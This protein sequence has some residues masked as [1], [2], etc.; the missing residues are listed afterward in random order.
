MTRIAEPLATGPF[1]GFF[2]EGATLYRLEPP[3]IAGGPTE[4]GIKTCE[5]SHII[6]SALPADSEG[7]GPE[8][9]VYAADK[10]GVVDSK[11]YLTFGVILDLNGTA[12]PSAA[13]ARLGYAA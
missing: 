3:V 12:D 13:L 7:N 1:H 5:V 4:R 6:V 10:Q 8:V 11:Y 9:V 2:H